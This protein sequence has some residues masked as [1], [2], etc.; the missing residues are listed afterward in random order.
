MVLIPG[1]IVQAPSWKEADMDSLQPLH[2]HSKQPLTSQTEADELMALSIEAGS[3]LCTA[4]SWASTAS[5]AGPTRSSDP[6]TQDS[7]R[8][9][10]PHSTVLEQG[11]YF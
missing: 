7:S 6:K 8:A 3:A 4:M 2:P 5:S 9:W 10:L 1:S 11:G